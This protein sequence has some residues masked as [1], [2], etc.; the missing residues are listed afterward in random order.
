MNKMID[1]IAEF[2]GRAVRLTLLILP[3]LCLSILL[4]SYSNATSDRVYK[5]L[6]EALEL[7]EANNHEQGL[8]ILQNDNRGQTTVL[9]GLFVENRGLSLRYLIMLFPAPFFPRR[10]MYFALFICSII[11]I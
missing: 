5:K 3:V 1:T 7:V 8:T 10:T 9:K 11:F 2:N 6:D 4:C